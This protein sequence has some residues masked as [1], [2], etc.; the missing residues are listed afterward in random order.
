[1]RSFHPC[2]TAEAEFCG[3]RLSGGR[4]LGG[5]SWDWL[6]CDRLL[7]GG[8]SSFSS[9]G[10]RG[11]GLGSRLLG[12]L[13]RGLLGLGLALDGGTELGEWGEGL[14]L[15]GLVVAGDRLLLLRQ[16]W[17]GALALLALGDGRLRSCGRAVGGGSLGWG[18]L[19]GNGG[20]Q[21]FGGFNSGD[22]WGCLSDRLGVLGR[23][24]RGLSLRLLVLAGEL[25]L[26]GAK[27][28][29][30]LGSSWLGGSLSWSSF[31]GGLHER[32]VVMG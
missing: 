1:M 27:D 5:G 7:D 6:S 12:G 8:G 4:N 11:G 19:G 25:R 17:Q 24:S 9:G 10:F 14:L 23:D 18:G 22:H 20:R 3:L 21:G 30:A 15:L 13:L 26:D 2:T 16:P 32:L 31:L 29:V 28:A